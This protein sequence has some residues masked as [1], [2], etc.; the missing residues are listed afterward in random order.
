MILTEMILSQ[1]EITTA[2]PV[3]HIAVTED[4]KAQ[5]IEKIKDKTIG[6]EMEGA[7]GETIEGMTEETTEVMIEVT[8]NI[9]QILGREMLV[10]CAIWIEQTTL[11][12]TDKIDV[13]NFQQE[14]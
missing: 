5:E 11:N 2:N 12:E 9:V 14:V 4:N 8:F 3:I 1:I 13:I 7:T 10:T 6:R